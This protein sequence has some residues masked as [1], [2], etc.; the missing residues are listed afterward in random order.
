MGTASEAQGTAQQQQ[1]EAEVN[2]TL[3]SKFQKQDF[4][5]VE[6]AQLID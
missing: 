5:C 2:S 1:Q 4:V 3:S 6:K